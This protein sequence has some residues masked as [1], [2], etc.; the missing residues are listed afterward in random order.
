MR[1]DKPVINATEEKISTSHSPHLATCIPS[2]ERGICQLAFVADVIW[3]YKTQNAV[4]SHQDPRS[5]GDAILLMAQIILQC[6]HEWMPSLG[7]NNLIYQL[8]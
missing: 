5:P 7:Y 8:R 6:A 4:E 2:A 3:R 1:K